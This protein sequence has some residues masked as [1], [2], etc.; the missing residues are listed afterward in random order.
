MMA[1]GNSF[2][3]AAQVEHKDASDRIPETS[4]PPMTRKERI[5]TTQK[6]T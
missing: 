4:L 3:P 5:V 1:S 2:P 6:I